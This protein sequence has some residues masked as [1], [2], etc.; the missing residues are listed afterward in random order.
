MGGQMKAAELKWG[1]WE[2]VGFEIVNTHRKLDFCLMFSTCC[3]S[4]LTCSRN[5]AEWETSLDF[6]IFPSTWEWVGCWQNI[7]LGMNCSFKL[8]A[9]ARCCFSLF[10]FFA[11]CLFDTSAAKWTHATRTNECSRLMRLLIAPFAAWQRHV[12]GSPLQHFLRAVTDE[13]HISLD[14]YGE[15]TPATTTNYM[16]HIQHFIWSAKAQLKLRNVQKYYL[17]T[18]QKSKNGKCSWQVTHL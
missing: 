15:M 7:Q 10:F 1:S 16:L 14:E 9:A 12:S 4:R 8:L 5:G 3:E 13:E 2:K 11:F 18:Q 17:H 6:F